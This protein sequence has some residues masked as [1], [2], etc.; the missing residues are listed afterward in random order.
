MMEIEGEGSDC[1]ISSTD[2]TGEAAVAVKIRAYNA[3]GE[4]AL[5]E[6]NVPQGTRLLLTCD[7]EGLLEG[8][9]VISYKWYHTCSTGKCEMQEGH[10]YY[11]AVND[12]L[13]VDATSWGGRPRRHLCKVK[14]Q[15]DK[16]RSGNLTT[17]TTLIRLAGKM[18]HQTYQC[19]HIYNAF[20]S[21]FCR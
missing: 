13:L 19:W 11:T 3:T 17:F 4:V 7:V 12:T 10:P 15:S 1:G 2:L 20:Y 9:V 18:I 21:S 8:N 6:D 14:Y 16:G 5:G